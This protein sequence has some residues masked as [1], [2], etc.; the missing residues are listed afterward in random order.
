MSQTI[1]IPMQ[2]RFHFERI[3]WRVRR[4]R[5]IGYEHETSR[6]AAPVLSPRLGS[7]EVVL[8][9]LTRNIYGSWRPMSE[10]IYSPFASGEPSALTKRYPPHG[11]LQNALFGERDL[12]ILVARVDS[13][14][15]S[16]P[17]R[18]R[19]GDA[20]KMRS[21]FLELPKSNI[22]LA[23]FLNTWGRWNWF[24][25][26]DITQNATANLK[27]ATEFAFY[28]V[29]DLLWE[30]QETYKAALSGDAKEWLA[31][32]ARVPAPQR[33]SE[34]P[35]LAV[36]DRFCETAIET[37]ITMDKLR[38]VPFQL[39]GRPD[40]GKIFEVRTKRAKLFCSYDCAHLTTV[41]RGREVGRKAREAAKGKA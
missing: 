13:T 6:E 40:C 37:T 28:V 27:D 10:R 16:A 36:I 12:D 8:K 11:V 1:S 20:W 9:L 24:G 2:V 34:P 23:R 18:E 7:N 19:V 33:T 32:H 38:D 29:P 22:A 21:E 41:R 25:L 14:S 5:V 4:A 26:R 39:C 15:A 30:Q 3:N 17:A 31:Q 35:F